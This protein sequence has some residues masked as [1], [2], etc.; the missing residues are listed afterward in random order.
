MVSRQPIAE[1]SIATNEVKTVS[2][3]AEARKRLAEARSYWLASVRPDGRPHVMPLFA[4]WLDDALYFTAGR[5]TRK[6]RNLAGNAHCVITAAGKGLDLIVEGK[7]MKVRDDATLQRVA[8]VYGSKY[9]WR[10]TV[11]DGAYSADFGAPSAGPPPYELYEVRP[12]KV[13]G[14]GTDEPYGATRWRFA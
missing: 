1:Q 9:N 8:D 7:A 5:N 13:F 6:A 14:L 11:H 4:V 3:W 2:E 10:V 12:T